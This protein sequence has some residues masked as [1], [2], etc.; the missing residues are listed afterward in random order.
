MQRAGLEVVADTGHH[1]VL[2]AVVQRGVASL[3]A[4]GAKK[5]GDIP[6]AAEPLDLPDE[7][8]PGLAGA[9]AEEVDPGQLV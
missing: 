3:A 6:C 4:L 9:R 1:R 5:D 8:G 2:G 7:R